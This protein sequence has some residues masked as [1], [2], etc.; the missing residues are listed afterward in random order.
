LSENETLTLGAINPTAEN[1]YIEASVDY[2]YWY[3]DE[4]I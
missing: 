1:F 2:L 4:Y 3:Y